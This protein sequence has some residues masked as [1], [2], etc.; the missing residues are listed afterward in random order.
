VIREEALG[1]TA[2]RLRGVAETS[3]AILVFIDDDNVVDAK[4][5]QAAVQLGSEWPKL[6]AWGGRI[7][8]VFE[9]PPPDWTRQYWDLLAIRPVSK[10]V[11]SNDFEHAWPQPIGAGLCIRRCVAER[12]RAETAI[13]AWKISLDRQ[14]SSLMSGG[15]TDLVHT[16]CDLGLGFGVFPELQLLHLIPAHRLDEDY[17]VRLVQEIA[18][19]E[20]LLKAA[21][22]GRPLAAK[23]SPVEALRYVARWLRLDRRGRRFLRARSQGL[24]RARSLVEETGCQAVR[25]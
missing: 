12:Y 18:T 17:L 25:P 20:A 23:S 13:H 21:R 10:E 2:A 16:A 3:G 6:G 1:L 24:R 19:S 15:D 22:S 9:V 5:L 14:G 7:D 8:P 4:Y 11:W